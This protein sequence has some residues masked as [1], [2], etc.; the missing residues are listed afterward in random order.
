MKS[1]GH[2]PPK[3]AKRFLN[4]F[5]RDDLAEEVQGDLEEQFYA[6]LERKSVFKA[7]LIY[8]F[9]VIN[10]LRPFAISKSSPTF[11]INFA[12]FRNYFK[13]SIRNLYKQK[14]YAAINIGGLSVGLT[15]FI[16]IFLFV[17]HELSYDRSFEKADQI[18][19][20][21]H[22]EPGNMYLGS[23]RFGVTPAPLA[24][25]I[26]EEYPE[27]KTAVTIDT[28]S[29][30]VGQA[31]ENNYLENGL[32]TDS[33]FFEILNYDFIHGEFRGVLDDPKS[34]VLTKTLSDKIFG[35]TF[36]VG[37]TVLYQNDELYTVTGVIDDPPENTSFRFSFVASIQS[38]DRYLRR[39]E[40]SNWNNNNYHT[41]L[42][43]S[44]DTDPLEFQ[45]KLPAFLDKY[46]EH[47]GVYL[48]QA[49]Q[50]MY[51]QSNINFDIGLKGNQ[52][53]VYLF[54]AIALI[55]LLLACANYMNLAIARSVN[56]AREVGLRKVVGAVRKQLIVQFLGES[57]LITFLALLL[58]LALTRLVLPVFGDLIERSIEL[59]FTENTLLIPGLF[60]LTFII[61]LLSGSYPA[62]YMSSLRPFQVI[63]GKLE[64]NA[65]GISLQKS[66]IVGQYALSIILVICSLV[67]Y[68][69]LQ[70][71]QNKELGYN[72]DHVITAH[73]RDNAL[74]NKY[75]TIREELLQNPQITTVSKSS[76]LPTQIN[77]STTIYIE[78]G[79][80]KKDELRIYEN[81]ITYDFLKVFDIPLVAG[82]NF[83]PEIKT[84][85][86]EGYILNETAAKALGWTPEEAIGQHFTHR[87]T[88][89]VVG[90]VKD[91]HMHSMHLSIQP[92]MLRLDNGYGRELSV[93][94]HPDGITET[95]I[96]MEKTFKAYSPYPFEYSFLDDDFDRLYK[97]E[98]KLGEIFGFFTV[99]S[100]L[101][102]SLGIFG[103]AAFSTGQRTKE[104]GIRK[105]LGASARNIMLLLSK[106]F[107]V[108]VLI[109]FVIALPFAWYAIY[110]WLQDFAYRINIE[111]WIFALAGIVVLLV[112]YLAIGYQS[113]KA[114]FINPVDSLRSE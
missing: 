4:W 84:D 86:E 48:V 12:M 21:Y 30:L 65:S 50:D 88:E 68:R 110:Q 82:R 28:E 104:I 45:E 13:I 81:L 91:F 42:L 71:I 32:L 1:N 113:I 96:S 23:D 36:P 5:L 87:G 85:L 78:E 102:A 101:I 54:S 46:T 9:Q 111:W 18:Y 40:R 52:R 75:E 3:S 62:M 76:S 107:L 53:Y 57:V 8:W 99:L 114:A 29:A 16:L 112:A 25:T 92:L 44:K 79:E 34:I 73:I 98:M 51:L 11:L 7:R 26:A 97:S 89:T 22:Q 27:V 24:P 35:N 20:V 47:H 43:L 72:K 19:R 39:M 10:Y 64:N 55:V 74:N 17:Q 2:I 49:L 37:Q 108:L 66:L 67:I 103:M 77:S 93:K 70:F 80:E 56:R 109:A 105:V 100:I 95:L 94:V 106:D 58:A 61:G 33:Q 63:T 15:S 60:I 14:L 83:S 38:N 41:F 69:Q 31:N 6:N 90:V 59:N